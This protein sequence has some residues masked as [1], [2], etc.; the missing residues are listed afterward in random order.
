MT[1]DRPDVLLT[2][3]YT[4]R[5]TARLLGLERH[6]ITRWKRQLKLVPH[7]NDGRYLG[8]DIIKAWQGKI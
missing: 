3:L 6:T 5:E 8:K 1:H 7:T 4:G 2:G